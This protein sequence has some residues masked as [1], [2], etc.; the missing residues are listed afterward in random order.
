MSVNVRQAA[1]ET[2]I[3]AHRQKFRLTADYDGVMGGNAEWA[4][5]GLFVNPDARPELGLYQDGP[6]YRAKPVLIASYREDGSIQV[7]ETE[8]AKKY[9]HRAQTA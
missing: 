1:L 6:E 5:W 2:A 4:Y 7:E 3:R 9:L 8:D